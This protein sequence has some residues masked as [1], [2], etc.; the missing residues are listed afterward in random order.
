[1]KIM[2][3]V[4]TTSAMLVASGFVMLGPSPAPVGLAAQSR[5]PD[6][7]LAYRSGSGITGAGGGAKAPVGVTYRCRTGCDSGHGCILRYD[8]NGGLFYC[9]SA[10]EAHSKQECA[11]WTTGPSCKEGPDTLCFRQLQCYVDQNAPGGCVQTT[12]VV[13]SS[14]S[15]I[16]N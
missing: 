10:L 3:A 5:L 6:S 9:E 14:T 4:L 8:D 7:V 12:T 13:G 15:A 11:F 2:F 1:M 16:C